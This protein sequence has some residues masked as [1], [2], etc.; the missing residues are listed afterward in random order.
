MSKNSRNVLKYSITNQSLKYVCLQHSSSY[1]NII[2]NI[3]HN[4]IPQSTSNM[5][6]THTNEDINDTSAGQVEGSTEMYIISSLVH[7]QA[8]KLSGHQVF[9][10][11]ISQV[12]RE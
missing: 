2:H 4:I 3:I 10:G 7:I 11:V 5:Y 9:L 1:C 12:Y 6:M 8:I